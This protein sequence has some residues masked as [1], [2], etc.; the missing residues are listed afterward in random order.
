MVTMLV[1]RLLVIR[2]PLEGGRLGFSPVGVRMRVSEHMGAN[3]VR[4]SAALRAVR[5]RCV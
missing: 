1:V 3:T 2:V 5:A 4:T